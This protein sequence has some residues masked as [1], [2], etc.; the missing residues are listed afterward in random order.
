MSKIYGEKDTAVEALKP[1]TFTIKSGERVAV[2]GASGAGKSTLLHL[3]GALDSPT[4]GT[5]T[6]DGNEIISQKDEKV[7]AFRLAN[8]GFVF[9][10]YHLLPELTAYENIVLPYLLKNAKIEKEYVKELTDKLGISGRLDHLPSQLSGG[11]QQ[12]VAIAR[13]LANRPKLLLCDEPTGN[14][15]T[16]N[17]RAVVSLLDQVADEYGLTVVTVTHNLQLAG[18][19]SRVLTLSDGIVGGDIE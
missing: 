13:A 4:G 12:R 1:C 19:Y 17:T 14:L 7:S 11:Q 3:L 15:D 2:V 5:V 6:Y 16:E 10:A 9:Q 18:G 8:I